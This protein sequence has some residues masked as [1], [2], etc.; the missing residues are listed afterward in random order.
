MKNKEESIYISIKPKFVKLILE[1]T[2]NYEFRKYIPK[3]NFNKIYIYETLP[4]AQIKYIIE[5]TNIYKYP[6]KIDELGYGNMEFNNGLK[7]SKFAYKLGEIYYLEKPIKLEELKSEYNF[8]PPQGFS[9]SEKYEKL[10][11]F[12]EKNLKKYK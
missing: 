12:I 2:K 6:N 11:E 10:T 9:Y 4:V 3:R 1:G 8:I 7:E 5:I